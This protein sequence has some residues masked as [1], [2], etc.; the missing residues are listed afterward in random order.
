MEK[1]TKTLIEQVRDDL[2][3]RHYSY[4][5]EETYVRWIKRFITFNDSKHPRSMREKEIEAFLTHLAVEGKV[6]SSTQNQALNALIFLYHQVLQME[7]GGPVCAVRAKAPKRL[8][9]VMTKGEVGKVIVSMRGTHQLMAKLLY[10]CGLRL[11][12]CLRLR[13]KDIDFEANQVIVRD[14]KG[15]K[16]RVTMLPQSVKNLLQQHLLEV[17]DLHQNDLG[18]GYGEVHMPGA[19]AR[20]YPNA[21]KAWIWQYVFPAAR[22]STDPRTAK[23]M[24]HHTH[25]NNLQK[26][27]K[28]AVNIAAVTKPVSCHTFRHS[29]ATHLLE[30]SHDI[31]TVQELLGHKDVSTTMIYTHVMNKGPFGVESPLDRL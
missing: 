24:R 6:A 12:E 11:M 20:K 1:P 9:T 13:I 29:F 30:D 4:R 3:R 16:D 7:L 5:T 23:V 17:K 18:K 28:K 10:G 8:P 19:L 25:P 21:G 31:R 2:R 14:G 15:A 27:V 22:L 26:A